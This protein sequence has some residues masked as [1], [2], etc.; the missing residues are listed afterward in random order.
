MIGAVDIGGTKIA[1]GIVD[2]DGTCADSFPGPYKRGGRLPQRY[3]R[4]C[5]HAA[6]PPKK[7]LARKSRE[8]A[9]VPPVRFIR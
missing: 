9:L 3:R 1:A 6:L 4:G 7:K 2:A 8:S 5:A